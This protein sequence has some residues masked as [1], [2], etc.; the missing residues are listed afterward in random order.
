MDIIGEFVARIYSE[1]RPFT[2][3]ALGNWLPTI[4]ILSGLI[5]WAGRQRRAHH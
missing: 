1:L 5:F 2:E 4:A 3:W